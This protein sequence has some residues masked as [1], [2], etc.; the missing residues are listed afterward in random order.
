LL[1][2]KDYIWGTAKVLVVKPLKDK[3]VV[4]FKDGSS[5]TAY[6]HYEKIKRACLFCGVMFY[7]V[8]DCTAKNNLI[9]ERQ[10]KRQ[11]S[12]DIP[13]HRF[14]QW[15]INERLIPAEIIHNTR[16]GDQSSNQQ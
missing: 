8:E 9:S 16:M 4:S 10:R 15:I 13:T 2:K 3:V 7:N 1:I 6:L 5:T 11:S 14:G 12:Q